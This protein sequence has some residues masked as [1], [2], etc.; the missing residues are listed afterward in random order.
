[1]L[2]GLRVLDASDGVA[3]GYC[4]KL[5]ADMGAD[6]TKVEPPGA[7][8]STRRTGPFAGD[9]PNPETSAPFLYLSAGKKSVTLDLERSPGQSIFRVL[10]GRA[11]IVVENFKPGVMAGLGLDYGT[12]H[13]ANPGLIMAS[14]TYFGQTGPYSSYEAC[15]LVAYAVS[16]YMYLTGDEDR[17][18]LKAGGNQSGYQAGLA[19][20]MAITAALSYRDVAGEGQYIDVSA[21]EALAS[22][23]DGVCVFTMEERLGFVPTRAGTRLI[24]REP[25]SPYP[26][27]LLPCKDGWVHVHWSPS[28]P[29][30]LA[31]LTGNPWLESD[32]VM[33]ALR[34][35]ADEI[36]EALMEWLKD[37]P[38]DEVQAL[39]QEVRVPFTKVQSIAEVMADP[40]NEA[41]G[42]FAEAE[43]PVAGKLR[44]PASPISATDTRPKPRRAPLLGEH[45]EEV[46]SGL[47]GY[48]LD[49]LSRLAEMGV[50]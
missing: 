25:H 12:L 18:P 32:E 33:G 9:V 39:A 23:F 27:N 50:I 29:E 7:G 4:T 28:H 48:A 46:Y 31:F 26:S 37:V 14:I 10:A 49:D 17:E 3:G 13:E 5:L 42:F 30:G 24:S 15:D 8:D 47:L 1:M 35:H 21:I 2:A 16:G 11:D 40:Q 19:A 44:Y 45:N 34:G 6:V 22:T 20:A 43:H 41:S 36:D 38:R